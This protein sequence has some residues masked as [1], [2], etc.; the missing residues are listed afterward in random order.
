MVAGHYSKTACMFAYMHV[1]MYE[2]TEYLRICACMYILCMHCESYV[3]ACIMH[4]ACVHMY[5]K[6]NSL[7]YEFQHANEKNKQ[8]IANVY[9]QCSL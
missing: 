7:K 8:I 6:L 9:D 1:C 3:H 4:N 5:T 2:R